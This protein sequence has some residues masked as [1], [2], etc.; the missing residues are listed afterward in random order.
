MKLAPTCQRCGST[1]VSR[2]G[3]DGYCPICI[4]QQGLLPDADSPLSEAPATE[5]PPRSIGPYELLA[6]IGRGGMG[7]VYKARQRSL[8][9]LVA[10]KLLAS[11]RYSSETLL[12][13]FQLEAESAAALQHPGIVAIHEFG[14]ADGQPFY[15]MEYVEGR[16]L[17]EISGGRPLEPHRAATY[18]RAIAEAV[19]YA[20]QHGILHRDLKPSNV[21]ID[22]EDRPR[23]TDFGL[24]KQLHSDT[25]VT[26]AGQVLGSPNYT[27]PEQA[28][29]RPKEIGPVSDV[30]SLGA[31]LYHL[32][33]GRP[34]FLAGTVQETL[35]LV[36]E[37]DPIAPRVL[38]PN[39]PADLDTICLKCLEKDPAR[40]YPSAQALADE[41]TRFLRGEPI[42]ARAI[43][44]LERGGR[45]CRR[46]PALAA[47]AATVV[48]ALSATSAVFYVS[49]HRIERAR[50]QEEAARL[51]AE[52]NFYAASMAFLGRG[53][54]VRN[55]DPALDRQML[56]VTRPR[57]GQRDLRGFEWNYFAAY[58][59]S[60]AL[61]AL[62]S[63]AHVVDQVTY[64]PDGAR[65]AS[66][67]LDGVLK[68]WDAAT[69]KDLRSLDGVL[70]AGGFTRDGNQFTFTDAKNAL[71]RLDI[72]TG[73][74]SPLSDSP[75][76]LIAALPDGR[77]VVVW[78]PGYLP[79]LHA[80]D[81]NASPAEV[82]AVPFGSLAAVSADS[83]RA[84][85]AVAGTGKIVVVDLSTKRT[86]AQISHP[87]PVT[88][89]ALSPDGRRVAWSGFDG[90]IWVWDIERGTLERTFKGFLDPIFGLAFS[91]DGRSLAAGGAN[92]SVGIWN[93]AD[94][95]QT[96]RLAGHESTIHCVAF[97][98][99]GRQLISGAED[100]MI[101]VWPA[102]PHRRPENMRRLLRGPDYFDRTPSL[103]FSPDSRLF[104]GTAADGTIKVW[105]TDNLE[106]VA[107][108][109]MEA[110]TV[111]FAADGQSVLGESYN[112]IVRRWLLGG[113]EPV[114]TLNPKASFAN[115]QVDSLTPQERVSFVADQAATRAQCRLCEIPSAR[116][117]IF[118]GAAT[119]APTIA[120]SPDGQ[121]MYVGLP[122]G[123][124]EVW[125]IASRHRQLAFK[126]HKLSITS[127]TASPD[128]RYLAT[129]S[130]DNFTKLW[131]ARTGQLVA[132]FGGHNR[133]VWALAFSPDGKT[134]AAGSCDKEII[135]CS[136][137]LR[138]LV[139]SLLLYD[140]IPEGYEQEVRLL[141]FSPD[142][143]ILAA[144]LGDGTLRFF[145]A[146]PTGTTA[147]ARGAQPSM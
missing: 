51:E 10:I 40:R 88:G 28:A 38:N 107:T 19:Q 42:Q 126:A 110:R 69:R 144:A 80:L 63:H 30:Y 44:S 21:L 102:H 104:T 130:L 52:E 119:S 6:E 33:T 56:A 9:R 127:I 89:L 22:Q 31:L 90:N 135:L 2:S 71:R 75:T 117:G 79:I 98:P 50:A 72:A 84:A 83:Q 43:S 115:W 32:L 53:M 141:K 5:R 17:S 136:V 27:A 143:T 95:S 85:A 20:H 105:R 36:H 112:G 29:G 77:H 61:S 142:G 99:D 24:A 45:W 1:L 109:P 16:N 23:I 25:E 47:L 87:R 81:G 41:L 116:D 82:P 57:S 146:E 97:A 114:Q 108:F 122:G 111:A 123:G 3:E 103:D 73:E 4:L 96:C 15:A 64:S 140:G 65:F 13:R 74:I 7:V 48:L 54:R 138:R 100:E 8:N 118:S 137:P 18:A 55:S 67:S 60:D 120:L 49:A 12:H 58:R 37:S 14:D 128:G 101:M 91:A 129:G 125:D 132:T 39:V 106:V 134:L 147:A 66:H 78:G 68:I 113:G 59:R 94:W 26:L 62:R 121:T 139:A 92:F 76:P 35:R 131:D 86:L 70:V 145:R 11:G 124:V 46:H 133:P 93:T 34:P